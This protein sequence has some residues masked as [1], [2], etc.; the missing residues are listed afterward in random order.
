MNSLPIIFLIGLSAVFAIYGKY[1]KSKSI[2]YV[3]KPLT[4]VLIILLAL[5]RTPA[6]PPPY[7]YLIL[8]AL[9]LSFIGDVIL[10]LPDKM[11]LQGLLPFLIAHIFYIL[12]FIQNVKFFSYQILYPILIYGILIYLGV[13]RTLSALR[14]PV[15]IYVLIISAMG[16]LSINR[17]VNFLDLKSLYV[18][19]GGILFL[20]SDSVWALNKFRKPFRSS[21]IYIL[22][23]YF[24]A[25]SLFALSI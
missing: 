8:A 5:I 16:W 25:Q 12:A 1:T 13:Y 21:E 6:L 14:I 7:C 2:H 9:I 19:I 15:F 22:G 3:F 24:S 20:I 18:M 23:S 17:Y 11:L 4:M 10:M